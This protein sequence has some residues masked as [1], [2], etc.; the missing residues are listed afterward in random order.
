MRDPSGPISTHAKTSAAMQMTS[1]FAVKLRRESTMAAL[2]SARTTRPP[3]KG[4][5]ISR[6]LPETKRV[7]ARVRCNCS[8]HGRIWI[9]R[10][11]RNAQLQPAYASRYGKTRLPVRLVT[12]GDEFVGRY[13]NED[14]EDVPKGRQRDLLF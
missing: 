2:S 11:M 5:S 6:L 7:A 10:C 8:G 14:R 13:F 4:A 12:H 9:D 1:R 3:V